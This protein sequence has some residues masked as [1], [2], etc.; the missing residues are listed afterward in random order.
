MW[1]F[2]NLIHCQYLFL[3]SIR[4]ASEYT[5]RVFENKYSRVHTNPQKVCDENG[6]RKMMTLK[7]N[8]IER[9][10]F[11]RLYQKTGWTDFDEVIDSWY[12]EGT[13]FEW[14]RLKMMI[15]WVWTRGSRVVTCTSI[16]SKN[17]MWAHRLQYKNCCC[18]G[19]M[20]LIKYLDSTLHKL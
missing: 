2:T 14:I 20:G 17:F 1:Q 12:N 16:F 7:N 6:E 5:K 10:D 4:Q 3:Y 18:R 13:I 11:I 8:F 15:I 9:K 19:W